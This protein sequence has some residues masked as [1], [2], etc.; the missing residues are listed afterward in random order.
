MEVLGKRAHLAMFGLEC[1]CRQDV[2]QSKSHADDSP[3]D[4]RWI[5]AGEVGEEE[6]E[7]QAHEG[8]DP[9]RVL[10]ERNDHDPT[11]ELTS[12]QC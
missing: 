6:T 2:L 4:V 8:G 1:D 11:L 9:R 3:A 10:E 5:W 12:S 7:H